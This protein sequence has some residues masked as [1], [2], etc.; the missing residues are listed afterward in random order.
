MQLVLIMPGLTAGHFFIRCIQSNIITP[1]TWNDG[2]LTGFAQPY[3]HQAR[4]KKTY[5]A[6]CYVMKCDVEIAVHHN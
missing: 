3:A 2:L 6:R 1:H 4:L 5:F